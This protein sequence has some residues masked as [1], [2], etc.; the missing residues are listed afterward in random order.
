MP[1][2]RRVSKQ[3][4]R[5]R[6]SPTEKLTLYCRYK[7]PFDRVRFLSR[8]AE[9][10]S[11]GAGQEGGEGGKGKKA[12][13]ETALQRAQIHLRKSNFTVGC[14]GSSRGSH[15]GG[16]GGAVGQVLG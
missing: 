9:G 10:G 8:G 12:V 5:S 15:R 13:S 14:W 2:H 3:C 6:G 1:L 11:G 7:G 4:E 16:R